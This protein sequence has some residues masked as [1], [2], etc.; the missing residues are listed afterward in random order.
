MSQDKLVEQLAQAA[1]G[2]RAAAE[3]DSRWER[4]T[5]GTLSDA[6]RQELEA[7]A[8]ADPAARARLEAHRPVPPESLDRIAAAAARELPS[9]P[10]PVIS[11]ASRWRR[12]QLAA[13]AGG[14]LAL[15]ASLLLVLA[16]P[17]SGPLPDYQLSVSGDRL[18]R[19]GEDPSGTPQVSTGARLS[20]L[21]R[22]EAPVDGPLEAR[23]FLLREGAAEAWEVPLEI[24]GEGAVRISGPVEELLPP[25][26]G[27]WTVAVAVGRRGQVPT[28]PAR[29]A[30][31]V[32]RGER[33]EGG[34]QLLWTEIER[35][36][37]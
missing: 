6:E 3:A 2:R 22:P 35:T 1:R 4:L 24:S 10:A 13:A 19:S 32:A 31:Q 8:A 14:A 18:V 11:L 5:A 30:A 29:I 17:R 25:G 7:M 21:L 15:A 12:L 16:P 9:A 27:R 23:A 37:R 28:Q 26:P 36:D 20:V 33:R 34:F